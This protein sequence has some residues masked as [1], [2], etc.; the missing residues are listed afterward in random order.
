LAEQSRERKRACAPWKMAPISGLCMPL[1][2]IAKGTSS[3]ITPPTCSRV[4]HRWHRSMTAAVPESSITCFAPT[5]VFQGVVPVTAAKQWKLDYGGMLKVGAISAA[6]PSPGAWANTC[7][8]QHTY[9]AC[10]CHQP[11]VLTGQDGERSKTVIFVVFFCVIFLTDCC[12]VH[13]VD[14]PCEC[15][16]GNR[17]E[18][19]RPGTA[20]KEG[21]GPGPHGLCIQRLGPRFR[22][23]DVCG[24]VGD[25]QRQACC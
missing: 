23:S 22:P 14:L 24:R 7:K 4:L 17:M 6:K 19:Q 15:H 16:V 13:R 2:S 3:M 25:S 9:D 8:E 10:R 12:A 11:V 18:G 5:R 20:E 21:A 1:A